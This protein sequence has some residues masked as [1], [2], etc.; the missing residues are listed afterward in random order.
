MLCNCGNCCNNCNG[1]NKPCNGCSSDYIN[2]LNQEYLN[3][4]TGYNENADEAMAANNALIEAMQ[5]VVA[6]AKQQNCIVQDIEECVGAYDSFAKNLVKQLNCVS[7][8]LSDLYG[9]IL[10]NARENQKLLCE[11]N[12]VGNVYNEI[13]DKLVRYLTQYK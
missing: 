10:K 4:N 1:C 7:E 9:A 6:I 13:L 8:E 12:E 2:G 11:M 3:L 5:N